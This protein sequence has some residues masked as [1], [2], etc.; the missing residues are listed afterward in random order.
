[1]PPIEAVMAEN[2]Q[3]RGELAQRDLTIAALQKQLQWLQQKVFGGGRGEKLE[4]AQLRLQLEELEAKIEQARAKETVTYERERPKQGRHEVPAERF[5]DLPVE[6]TTVITPEEVKAEPQA[7]EQIGQEETFEVEIQPPRLYKHQIIRT[8][9]RLKADRSRAPVIAPA[10]PRPIQGSY[11]SAGLLAWVVLSKYV[12]HMPLYRQEKASARWGAALSRKTM[13]DWVEAVAQWLKPIY[14]HMRQ[15][16]LDGGYVQADETPVRYCDPDQ[17]KAGTGQGWLWGI[18][19]PGGEV[20]FAW[21]L[22]RRHEEAT[23]LLQ[24]FSGLLQTDGY[25]AYEAFSRTGAVTWIGCWAHARR[26]FFESLKE[27]PKAAGLVLKLIGVLY[28]Q[29]ALYREEGLDGPQRQARRQGIP[30]RTLKWLRVA[31]RLC[32]HR[33]LP[34]SGLGKA[35]SYALG[36]WESLLAYLDHGQVEIDNNLQE[37]AIRP[38]A[39]GKKNFLFVGAPG[40]GERS[41]IIYSIVVSCQRFGIDPLVYLRE[42]LTRLPAMTNQDDLAALCPRNWKPAEQR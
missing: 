32:A 13:A 5:K 25:G 16:L 29:E 37:N 40:A 36:H 27:D 17:K 14:H 18:S 11:A 41:A 1:M 28:A 21:R 31:I 15:D 26:K 23:T 39:L 7:Y 35:C 12:E 8:K 22:S 4:A 20:C 9:H 38:S 42:V 10:P 3:L 24:G 33:A 6:K 19:R 30:R 34:K 2:E